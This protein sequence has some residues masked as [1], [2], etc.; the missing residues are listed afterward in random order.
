MFYITS[1]CVA[2]GWSSGREGVKPF[3]RN[4]ANLRVSDTGATGSCN[5]GGKGKES[6]N[7]HDSSMHRDDSS[8]SSDYRDESSEMKWKKCGEDVTTTGKHCPFNNLT[9][10]LSKSARIQHSPIATKETACR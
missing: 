6:E 10:R 7:S 9:M 1:R 4:C 3:L 8:W 5:K 2:N